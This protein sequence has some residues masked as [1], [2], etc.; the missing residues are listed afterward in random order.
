MDNV[1]FDRPGAGKAVEEHKDSTLRLPATVRASK[2][3][4]EKGTQG[5]CSD[6]RTA[7]MCIGKEKCRRFYFD[8]VRKP[9]VRP[10]CFLGTG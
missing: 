8:S 3:T 10:Q 7:K 1:V 9:A 2:G 5:G 6:Q 4:V